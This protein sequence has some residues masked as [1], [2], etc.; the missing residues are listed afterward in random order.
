MCNVDSE[1]FH[2]SVCFVKNP[3]R[4]GN[5]L[6]I[7]SKQVNVKSTIYIN[8]MNNINKKTSKV[9]NLKQNS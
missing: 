8:F 1:K 7:R 2:F 6:K 9:R 3:N 5:Y 4:F